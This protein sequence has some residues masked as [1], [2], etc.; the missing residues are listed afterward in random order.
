[1]KNSSEAVYYS[2]SGKY[3]ANALLVYLLVG[4]P[5]AI[6]W[7]YAYSFTLVRLQTAFVAFIPYILIVFFM[8]RADSLMVVFYGKIRSKEL[9]GTLGII[10][11]I[12]FVYVHWAVWT[13]LALRE[14]AEL[15]Y[16]DFA[17]AYTEKFEKKFFPTLLIKPDLLWDYHN[18]IG[19]VGTWGIGDNNFSGI[20]LHIFWVIEASLF[21]S[22]VPFN[23]R[24]RVSSR[25][26]CETDNDWFQYDE[27]VPLTVIPQPADFVAKLEQGD[28][29]RIYELQPTQ[30]EHEHSFH[31]LY[32]SKSKE[33]YL[34]TFNRVPK[35]NGDKESDSYHEQEVVKNIRI[36]SKAG[37]YL[38][39]FI[40][41]D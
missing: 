38:K 14:H 24:D 35:R 23:F 18:K 11:A 33:Y 27:L 31:L 22:A 13:D 32:Y 34:K 17:I 3:S 41:E 15:M 8:A 2:P 40:R 36:D 7:A 37:N 10:S 28:Y 26:F 25:P 29:S 5:M 30:R 16:T 1:M 4:V 19:E 6:A 21:F 12:V 20:G 39:K 9:A